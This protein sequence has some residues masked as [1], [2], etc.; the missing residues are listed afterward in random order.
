MTL[1]EQ[2]LWD[3]GGTLYPERYAAIPVE[4]DGSEPRTIMYI[5]ELDL[6]TLGEIWDISFHIHATNDD[7]RARGAGLYLTTEIR[8]GFTTNHLRD[9]FYV[10]KAQGSFNIG[11]EA[12]HGLIIRRA[13]FEWDQQ[14]LDALNSQTPIV[15]GIIWAGSTQAQ[16]SDVCAIDVGCGHL[17]LLRH[18]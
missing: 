7:L 4:L 5:N 3:H 14:K 6:P 16:G 2:K 11:V 10:A 9:G 13:L 1:H 8:I 12:H 15:K 18:F 17:K